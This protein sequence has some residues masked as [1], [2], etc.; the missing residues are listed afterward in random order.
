MTISANPEVTNIVK[1]SRRVRY[2]EIQIDQKS[3]IHQSYTANS[4]VVQGLLLSQG[5][6]TACLAVVAGNTAKRRNLRRET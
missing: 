6:P 2:C 1:T 4:R 5:I 3:M